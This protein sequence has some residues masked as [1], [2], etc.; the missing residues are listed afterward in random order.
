VTEADVPLIGKRSYVPD[1]KVYFADFTDED[2][3][4]FVAG[5]LNSTLIQEY[6][7]SHTIQIQV[8][9]IFKHLSIPEYDPTDKDHRQLVKAAKDAHAAK[10]AKTRQV[11][12]AEI[13]KI[14]DRVLT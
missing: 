7:E 3:A 2:E 8:S 13:D 5:T 14:A 1:H 12:L 9:N 6:I 4:Y 10:S 11:L